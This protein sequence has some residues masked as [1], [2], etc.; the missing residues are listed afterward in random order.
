MSLLPNPKL[1]AASKPW[2]VGCTWH[3]ATHVPV[4]CKGGYAPTWP[5]LVPFLLPAAPAKPWMVWLN[6]AAHLRGEGAKNLLP[7]LRMATF[8]MCRREKGQAGSAGHGQPLPMAVH[9]AGGTFW[10]LVH[11]FY[12]FFWQ[13]GS[14]NVASAQ[15]R[16]GLSASMRDLALPGC[17]PQGTSRA[18]SGGTSTGLWGS[19]GMS[20][21]AEGAS[22]PGTK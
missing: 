2:P 12:F 6:I 19:G 17:G 21:T 11:C 10:L 13:G 18:R 9:A 16:W 14:Q 5:S 7:T 8:G 15:T 3:H 1:A 22:G 20:L 4:P